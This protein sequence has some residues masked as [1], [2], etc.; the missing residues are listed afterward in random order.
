MTSPRKPRSRPA[1]VRAGASAGAN[2]ARGEH[3]LELSGRSYRL[4]P[5]FEAA[6][7]IEV[8]TGRALIELLRDANTMALSYADLGTICA[9]YIRAGAEDDL[10]R[11][12]SAERIAELIYEE[13]TA[14]VIP[15]VTLVLVDAISGGRTASG[16]AKAMTAE[17]P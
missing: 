13:G 12:I 6:Q 8:E 2:G 4:R 10:T 3:A 5:S 16:E 14:R 1:R 15:V 7:A 17:T 9:E 11:R